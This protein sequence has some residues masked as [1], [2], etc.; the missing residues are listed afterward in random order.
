MS[1][2]NFLN[3]LRVTDIHNSNIT[4]KYYSNYGNQW[5][6]YYGERE[7]HKYDVEKSAFYLRQQRKNFW[8]LLSN[9]LG[10]P[11]FRP[12][13]TNLNAWGNCANNIFF[14]KVKETE[15]QTTNLLM[16]SMHSIC[17]IS[18][19]LSLTAYTGHTFV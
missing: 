18:H 11:K 6:I 16:N 14:I 13:L 19:C 8:L 2:I 10:T 9:S 7:H 3:G 12:E 1:T 15:Y 4:Q 5:C 17:L